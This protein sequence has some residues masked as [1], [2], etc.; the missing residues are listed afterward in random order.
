MKV[1]IKKK[2]SRNIIGHRELYGILWEE[3]SPENRIPM[4]GRNAMKLDQRIVQQ[5]N[6]IYRA[7]TEEMVLKERN[8]VVGLVAKDAV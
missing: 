8:S 7:A 5:A 2:K 1:L 6:T 4:T 3:R